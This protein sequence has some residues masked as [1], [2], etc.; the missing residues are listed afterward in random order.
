M[1][2]EE[3]CN[4]LTHGEIEVVGRIAASSNQALFVEVTLDGVTVPACHKTEL[5]ERPLWDFPEGLWKREVA[6]YRVAQYMGLDL[7]PETVIRRDGPFGPGSLQRWIESDTGDHYFTLRENEAL[8]PWFQELAA[9]DVVANNTDRKSGHIIWDGERC[10]A[11]D[12]GLC[13]GAD[14]KLRTVIWDFAGEQLSSTVVTSLRKLGKIPDQTVDELLDID[15]IAAIRLRSRE[16]LAHGNLPFPDEE[17]DWPPYPW[18][19]I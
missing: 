11:I 19:L 10:W 16:L 2:P 7:V 14:E 9:F 1:R 18:P 15:E 17:G 3:I 5:G 8:G 4:V 6:A 12:Q 13:F